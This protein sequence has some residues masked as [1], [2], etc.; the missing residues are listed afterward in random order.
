M[1]IRSVPVIVSSALSP[2]EV[3]TGVARHNRREMLS[4]RQPRPVIWSQITSNLI[5]FFAILTGR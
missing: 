2:T 1:W 3:V 4:N 5:R